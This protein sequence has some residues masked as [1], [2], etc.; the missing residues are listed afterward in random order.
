M[1]D[2]WTSGT[3]T[4]AFVLYVVSFVVLL[5]SQGRWR[6]ALAFEAAA[7]LILVVHVMFAFHEHHGWSHAAAE[8]HVANETAQTIGLRWGGGIYFNHAMLLLWAVSMGRRGVQRSTLAKGP[9]RFHQLINVYVLLMWI[10][11][12]IVFGSTAFRILGI[13]GLVLISGAYCLRKRR[14]KAQD[15][16]GGPAMQH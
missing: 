9:N 12:T 11:A 3:A 7:W 6:P 16:A 10:S 5:G 1:F 13:T 2:S 14:P 15:A 8:Q 4:L